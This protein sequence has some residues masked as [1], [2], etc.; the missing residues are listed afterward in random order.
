MF[1]RD[2][3]FDAWFAGLKNAEQA[4]LES[5]RL[6]I[7]RDDRLGATPQLRLDTVA[8]AK[9]MARWFSAFAFAI[10]LWAMVR[11]QPDALAMSS[12]A[13]LPPLALLTCWLSHGAFTLNSRKDL[14]R[15]DLSAAVVA[16]AAVIALRALFDY[17]L[18]HP[19]MLLV[20][21]LV[22]G[23]VLTALLWMACADAA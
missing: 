10:A 4:A 7:Q 5:E 17:Q 13:A 12:A 14:M 19:L 20:P 16:P 6:T 11:P 15:G 9:R 1:R 22:G 2:S 21:A 23:L 8:S 3:D 18:V